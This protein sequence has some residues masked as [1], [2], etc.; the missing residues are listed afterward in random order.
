MSVARALERALADV[1]AGFDGLPR[2]LNL[3]GRPILSAEAAVSLL[4]GAPAGGLRAVA[5]GRRWPVEVEGTGDPAR[6]RAAFD[7]GASLVLEG[8]RR[9]HEGVR[10]ACQRAEARLRVRAYGNAYVSP[11]GRGAFGPHHDLQGV[12]VL[13]LAGHKRWRVGDRAVDRP[14]A[15]HPC[16]ADGVPLGAPRFDDVLA[17]G[18]ALYVPRGFAHV[19]EALDTPSV[20]L[21]LTLRPLVA[22]D[23]LDAAGV[24]GV[25]A[26][27]T[28]AWLDVP[29]DA[30]VDDLPEPARAGLTEAGAPAQEALDHVLDAWVHSRPVDPAATLPWPHDGPWVRAPH[31]NRLREVP[32]GVELVAPGI[33]LRFPQ[34]TAPSLR[35]ALSGAPF[36]AAELPGLAPEEG[37][38]LTAHLRRWRLVR[39]VG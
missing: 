10:D 28:R 17:P 39:G 34:G 25:D 18:E 19:A 20:H 38:A 12:V 11:P 32:G 13:Q 8:L 9:R 7:E 14:D 5:P 15:R 3:D 26:P 37:V 6:A 2:R 35:R 27:W 24:P 1:A 31:L 16:P 30:T 22:H 23:L 36:E 21:S 4:D 33:R 29:V